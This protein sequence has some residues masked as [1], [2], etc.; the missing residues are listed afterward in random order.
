MKFEVIHKSSKSPARS[1]RLHLAHGVVETPV[2][3][4][5]GT[6]AAVKAMTWEQVRTMGY[7]M[8]LANT[9]HLHLRPGDERIRD[10]GG[11]HHFMGWSKPILTDSGGYQVFSLSDLREISEEGVHFASPVDGQRL[12]IGPEEAIRIQQNLGADVIMAFDECTPYPCEEPAARDS[13]ELTLR[14][15]ERC[16]AAHGERPDQALFGIVQGSVYPALRTESAR[17]TVEI[18]FPGYAVGGLSV[19]E[20]K[21]LMYAGLE[22]A[23]AELPTDSPRYAMGVGTPWDFLDCVERG[24]DMFDCVMPTRVA[25]NGRVYVRGGKRNIRNARYAD[26]VRPLDEACSCE[27]CRNHSRAYLRHLHQVGEIAAAQLL[28]IH[29]L[30]FFKDCMDEIRVAIKANDLTGLR[31][32]WH[33]R[34]ARF[35]K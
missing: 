17:R 5:V 1:A 22:A 28:T 14:W 25:R 18:G 2:F 34:E 29:N 6:R 15:A 27:A 9:F 26:D 33:E 4:P 13:M 8:V 3:M 10:L 31:Q 12:F 35:E 30:Q 7:D 32:Q 11:L 19:G 21:D 23:L 24:V 16:K 20:P